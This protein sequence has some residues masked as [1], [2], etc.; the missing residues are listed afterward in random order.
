MQQIFASLRITYRSDVTDGALAHQTT[1]AFACTRTDIDDVVCASNRVFIML[2]HNQGIAFA[3]QQ[4]QS[5][6]QDLVIACMQSNRGL[7]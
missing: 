5:V 4:M 1:T 6:Q 7:I 2:D 3:T